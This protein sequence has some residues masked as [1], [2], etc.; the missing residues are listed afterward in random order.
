VTMNGE[1]RHQIVDLEL[2]DR[3][4]RHGSIVIRR[5]RAG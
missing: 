3:I 2:V 1:E 4:D 5:A